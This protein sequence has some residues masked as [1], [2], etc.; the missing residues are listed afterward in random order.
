M[1]KLTPYQ[2]SQLPNFV[3]GVL[4]LFLGAFA[5]NEVHS[6]LGIITIV[7]G[8]IIM[9]YRFLQEH[10]EIVKMVVIHTI[11][12]AGILL[13]TFGILSTFGLLGEY[14]PRITTVHQITPESIMLEWMKPGSIFMGVALLI[15]WYIKRQET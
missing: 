12:A 15:I 5:Y 11:L 14:F 8:I 6:I 2:I 7:I 13:F 1:R 4:V 3:V 10:K 9:F